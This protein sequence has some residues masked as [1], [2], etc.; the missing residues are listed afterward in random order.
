[1][2]VLVGLSD[3]GMPGRPVLGLL[4]GRTSAFRVLQPQA[5]L[6]KCTGIAGLAIDERHV[7][8][9]PQG[10]AVPAGLLVL[11]RRDLSLQGR[12]EFPSAGG[13]H[14]ILASGDTLLVVSTDT[15]EVIALRMR[16]P[17][18]VS[19]E[20]F[21]RPDPDAPRTDLHHLNAIC[22]WHGDVLVSGFGRKD[23]ALWKT[24]DNGF[25]YNITQRKMI[26]QGLRHPH[27]LVPMG[28]A[29][30]YCES[31]EWSVR[32]LGDTRT[33]RLG[34][35]ALGLCLAGGKLFVGTSRRRRVS[36]STGRITETG[37]SDPGHCAVSRLSAA[38]FEIEFQPPA[39]LSS[40]PPKPVW[41]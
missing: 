37:R 32:V 20:V 13:L 23:G 34:G 14:S 36:K 28:D 2:D 11:D 8:A 29:I 16:G 41:V 18:V 21:W 27:S 12:H 17:E 3:V 24:A 15:D 39:G 6:P 10:D 5:G 7:Y 9:A 35:Y 31:R 19:E 4:D 22:S 30:T 38:T 1:M 26:A 25:I 40:Q 33:Q